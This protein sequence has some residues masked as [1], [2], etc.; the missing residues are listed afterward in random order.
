MGTVAVF[1]GMT[2]M[3]YPSMA[4]HKPPHFHVAFDNKLAKYTIGECEFYKGNKLPANKLKR[5]REW[6]EMYCPYLYWMQ[7]NNDVKRLP[8]LSHKKED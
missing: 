8:P 1:D 2:I 3:L 6:W 5:L 7:E 4:D